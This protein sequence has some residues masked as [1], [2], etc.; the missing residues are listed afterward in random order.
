MRSA[1]FFSESFIL[2]KPE[3]WD[4]VG[5]LQVVSYAGTLHASFKFWC[6]ICTLMPVVHIIL[7]LFFYCS[8]L[9]CYLFSLYHYLRC[10][11]VLCLKQNKKDVRVEWGSSVSKVVEGTHHMKYASGTRCWGEMSKGL[12]SVVWNTPREQINV[13]VELLNN[14]LAVWNNNW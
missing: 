4:P 5:S 1:C 3:A 2:I 11:V 6:I 9:Y 14:S 12:I 10:T 8:S 7:V 13:Q